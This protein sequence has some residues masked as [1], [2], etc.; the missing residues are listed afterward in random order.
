MAG[1]YE[2]PNVKNKMKMEEI[3]ELLKKW[4]LESEKIE[5]IG[6]ALHVF[7]HIEWQMIGHLIEVKKEND[8]FL[9]VSKEEL[10]KEYA[11]PSAF[12]FYKQ[13]LL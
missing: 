12:Q 2:F 8:I 9:W 6:E 10:I 1:M 3:K 13:K 11:L 7:S 5:N 4:N